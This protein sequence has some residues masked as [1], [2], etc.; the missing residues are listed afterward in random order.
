MQ[1]S[2]LSFARSSSLKHQKRSAAANCKLCQSR[3]ILFSVFRIARALRLSCALI[4]LSAS[5][6]NIQEQGVWT[7]MLMRDSWMNPERMRSKLC[8]GKVALKGM[9]S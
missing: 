5:Y 4:K 7:C 8:S 3:F 1:S 6:S 9:L 2:A